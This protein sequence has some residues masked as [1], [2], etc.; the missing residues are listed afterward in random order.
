MIFDAHGDILTD[1]SEQSK[2]GMKNT[3]KKRHLEAYK[4]GG[5]T[6]SIFVNWTDPKSDDANTFSE[7][8]EDAFKEIEDNSD[9]FQLCYNYQDMLKSFENNKIGVILGMEGIKHLR[10][11]NHLNELYSKGVRHASLTWNEENKYASGLDNKFD[12]LKPLGYE[13]ITEMEKLGMI[14]DLAHTNE[15][16]FFDIINHTKKPVIISH[17]NAKAK[18][19]H[20]RNYTDKQLQA[21]KEKN[22][23]I[24]VCAIMPFVGDTVEDQ[25]VQYISIILTEFNTDTNEKQNFFENRFI[26][27]VGMQLPEL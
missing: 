15:A 25:T 17:G 13:I 23:V 26:A 19:S 10:D 12:G 5:I 22:G 16:T 24:G 27:I 2:N 21:I 7:I 14:V 1:M 20:R 4:K 18:C 6:H 3:F 11:V 8:F 9:I